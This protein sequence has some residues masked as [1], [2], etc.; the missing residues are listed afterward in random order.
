MPTPAR[1]TAGAHMADPDKPID[2][3][4]P[5]EH[6][7]AEA[8]GSAPVEPVTRT[9]EGRF[10]V[11]GGVRRTVARG[12]LVNASFL[13]VVSLL[14][15]VKGVLVAGFLSTEDYGLWGVIA[16]SVITLTWLAQ[17]GIG[18]KYVQQEEGDQEAAFQKAFTL[19]LVFS[20]GAMA[21]VALCVPLVGLAYGR[22]DVLLPALVLAL[23]LPATAFTSPVWV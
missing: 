6:P 12:T 7:P 16:V 2:D 15:L 3:A 19:E 5:A 11:V 9:F 8:V 10:S 14:G 4:P 1:A 21:F 22:T 13:V 23:A 18:D 20:L 17:T